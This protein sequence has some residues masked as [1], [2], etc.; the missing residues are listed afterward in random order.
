MRVIT[1]A[2]TLTGTELPADFP[3]ADYNRIWA[4]GE[5]FEVSK[6]ERLLVEGSGHQLQLERPEVVLEAI[7]DVIDEARSSRRRTKRRRRRTRWGRSW[8]SK[9]SPRE[10][11]AGPTPRGLRVPWRR[12][13]A[14]PGCRALPTCAPRPPAR[15]GSHAGSPLVGLLLVT[16]SSAQESGAPNDPPRRPWSRTPAMTPRWWPSSVSE[17]PPSRR[18]PGR[19]SVGGPRP[20]LRGEHDRSLAEEAY[21][22]LLGINGGEA[23]W[24]Y[25]RGVALQDRRSRGRARRLADAANIY[26]NTPGPGTP[27][28]CG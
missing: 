26:K 22:G 9:A 10:G 27:T 16:P 17:S 12:A 8:L 24:L 20:R 11:P 4:Q 18:R 6:A 23:Q 2:E 19:E 21:S 14:R 3:V 25:R 28:S 13:Q 5:R 15:L 1:S 7:L